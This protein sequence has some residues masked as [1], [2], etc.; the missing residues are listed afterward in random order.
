LL[1]QVASYPDAAHAALQNSLK[2][3]GQVPEVL[4]TKDTIAAALSLDE[5]TRS[6]DRLSVS[7]VC[8]DLSAALAAVG[9]LVRRNSTHADQQSLSNITKSL[10]SKLIRL[11]KPTK[12]GQLRT[13]TAPTFL[14]S[15]FLA[16]ADLS[17]WILSRGVNDRSGKSAVGYSLALRWLRTLEFIWRRSSS[18]L[19]VWSAIRFLRSLERA[20]PIS[21]Y[22]RLKGEPDVAGF[23][24]ATESALIEE[25]ENALIA[26]RVGDLEKSLGVIAENTAKRDQLLSRLRG[27]CLK[28]SSNILPEAAEWVARHVQVSS[29]SAEMLTAADESQSSSLDYISLCLLSAWDAASGGGRSL[30]TLE[31]VRR[32]ARDLFAIFLKSI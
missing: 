22:A 23:M 24:R 31:N 14:K 26:G 7:R 1:A 15:T 32:L 27:V 28:Q 25:A 21:I 17:I 3:R 4:I 30:E 10:T 18:D 8:L 12:P 9:D 2:L 6:L 13:K 11:G 20:V 29:S 5:I 16:A 19:P